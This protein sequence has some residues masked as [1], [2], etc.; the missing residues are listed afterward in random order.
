MRKGSAYE[1]VNDVLEQGCQNRKLI[2]TSA[3]N[4]QLF[5]L[6][7]E[8]LGLDHT[9]ILY[10]TEVRWLSRG[11]TTKRLFEMKNELLLFFQQKNHDF[12]N[13]LEDEKFIAR[14]AYLSDMYF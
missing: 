4:T 7:C 3:L 5:K 9:C 1:V 11:N 2:K 10:H 6:L 12:Q 13:D 8:D 14:L